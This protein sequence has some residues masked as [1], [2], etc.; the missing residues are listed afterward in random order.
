VPRRQAG[1]PPAGPK[2]CR[3][4]GFS[5]TERAVRYWRSGLPRSPG[6]TSAVSGSCPICLPRSS[7]GKDRQR[8]GRRR[9]PTPANATLPLLAAALRRS[10]RPAGARGHG[11]SPSPKPGYATRSCALRNTS[12]ALWQRW[13]GD[14]RRSCIDKDVLREA[15]GHRPTAQIFGRQIAEPQVRI[16]ALNGCIA[17]GKPLTIAS[18]NLRPRH[19]RLADM[20]APPGPAQTAKAPAG[21]SSGADFRSPSMPH[22]D[23][24][25]TW[26][27]SRRRIDSLGATLI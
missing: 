21:G 1:E 8:H 26:T 20:S 10:Y 22:Q 4:R 7:R 27:E 14:L 11:R 23:N 5:D 24:K 9:P 2:Q 3:H 16:T 19:R 15:S 13:G 17:L 12:A 6:A 25:K 18:L